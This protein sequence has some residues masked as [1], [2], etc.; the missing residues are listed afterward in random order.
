MLAASWGHPETVGA[1]LAKGA[2]VNE[3]DQEGRTALML[4]AFNDRADDNNRVAVVEL[5]LG[6]QADV[7]LQDN[8]GKTA[9][10]VAQEKDRP[11]IVQLLR[12]AGAK[13]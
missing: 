4:A 6:R 12:K 9:L 2:N 13:K 1:L 5:L 8:K 11:E 3:Q 7:N 10:M